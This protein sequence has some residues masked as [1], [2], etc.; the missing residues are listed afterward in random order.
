MS[1]ADLADHAGGAVGDPYQIDAAAECGG[2]ERMMN[3]M[4]RIC[5]SR[6][7]VVDLH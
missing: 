5:K 6:K 4:R 1:E 7:K 3:F 2:I